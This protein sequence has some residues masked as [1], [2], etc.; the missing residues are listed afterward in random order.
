M[1]DGHARWNGMRVHDEV[2]H[3]ALCCEGHVL[4]RVGDA[5]SP[6]LT[7]ARRKLVAHLNMSRWEAVR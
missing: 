3:D 2:G 5:H 7:V 6:L 1:A 4:L